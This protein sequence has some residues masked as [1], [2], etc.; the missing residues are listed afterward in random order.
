M[1]LGKELIVICE[2]IHNPLFNGIGSRYFFG[3]PKAFL[4]TNSK[5]LLALSLAIA[6]NVSCSK[7]EDGPGFSFIPAESRLTGEWVVIGY[8][9]PGS[10]YYGGDDDGVFKFE[11]DKDGEGRISYSYEDAGSSYEYGYIVE[12]ELND[13]ELTLDPAFYDNDPAIF[14][15][16]RLTRREMTLQVK[17]DELFEE[18]LVLK[19]EK[20]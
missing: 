1:D 8:E 18:G 20:E 4:M 14:E 3:Q 17:N 13:N 5:Y 15:V 2:E 7:F 6:L 16:Q 10:Q 11:F 19:M 9:G 12:W